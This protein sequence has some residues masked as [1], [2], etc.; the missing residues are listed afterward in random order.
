MI[1]WSVESKEQLIKYLMN[2]EDA[3]DSSVCDI[4]HPQAPDRRYSSRDQTHHRSSTN[5]EAGAGVSAAGS[6]NVLSSIFLIKR[7]KN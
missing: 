6:I 2:I 7:L 1:G 3:M 4:M 5:E